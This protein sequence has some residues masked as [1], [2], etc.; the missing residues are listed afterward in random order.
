MNRDDVLNWAFAL[1]GDTRDRAQQQLL[2]LLQDERV[3]NNL[4]QAANLRDTV[5]QQLRERLAQLLPDERL[6]QLEKRF[7]AF[8]RDDS[9]TLDIKTHLANLLDRALE[10]T[11]DGARDALIQ[12]IVKQL[13][14]DEARILSAMSD[15]QPRALVHLHAVPLVGM[16]G[17]SVL[18][19]YSS[20][21]KDV[22]LQRR[23]FTSVYIGRLRDFGLLKTGAEDEQLT[24][25]YELLESENELR[26]LAAEIDK[27]TNQ[28]AKF[29]RAT[30]HLTTLGQ[31]LCSIAF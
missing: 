11:P 31:E 16:G 27:P 7:A 2:A 8:E 26:R 18:S 19:N 13:L 25:Q 30:L 29:I 3:A 15:R 14:P 6:Q 28:R 24:T 4:A 23:D 21:G 22:G 1:I 20:V 12:H 5:Q 10:Q 9:T 17:R